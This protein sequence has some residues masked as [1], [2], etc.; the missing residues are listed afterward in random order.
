MEMTGTV[1]SE[2]PLL[3]TARATLL[4]Q[5]L[6]VLEAEAGA[7]SG[8]DDED[9][10]QMRVASRRLRA[11]VAVYSPLFRKSE[12]R[13]RKRRLRD[14]TR[15]LGAA[16]EWDVHLKNLAKEQNAAAEETERAALEYAAA[17]MRERR[18]AVRG[19]MIASLDALD[20]QRTVLGAVALANPGGNGDRDAWTL[21]RLADCV[22]PDTLSEAWASIDAYRAT[23]DCL[24][25]H[26]LRIAMKKLRYA[27]EVLEY[28]FEGRLAEG[29][30]K[31]HD[32]AKSVQDALG[33]HHDLTLLADAIAAEQ[34][35]LREISLGALAAALDPPIA[36]LR[37]RAEEW[38]QEF[39]E[40]TAGRDAAKVAA[41]LGYEAV[42]EEKAAG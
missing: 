3:A 7:R 31:V 2:P 32:E 13:K 18:D 34:A 20:V 12:L 6:I 15:A 11:A 9:L 37:A 10:H 42:D 27:L 19:S 26:E 4:K 25:L 14:L 29:R 41:D 1:P 36:R 21:E 38:R 22:V 16:R 24:R 17:R 30:D 39:L 8:E 40:I 23:D 33:K 35:R 28:A 5:G